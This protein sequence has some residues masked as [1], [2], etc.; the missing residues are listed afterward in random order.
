LIKYLHLFVSSTLLYL[1]IFFLSFVRDCASHERSSPYTL[2]Q[3]LLSGRLWNLSKKAEK[4]DKN[5]SE[6]WGQSILF[7]I[8]YFH[9]RG[10]GS[11]FVGSGYNSANTWEYSFAEFLGRWVCGNNWTEPEKVSTET[12]REYATGRWECLP[13]VRNSFFNFS[14]S[15][16]RVFLFQDGISLYQVL[17]IH[18]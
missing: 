16:V 10:Y 11:K 9:G 3:F 1:F 2:L 17:I 7:F 18:V 5:L 6:A 13:W 12:C 14:I 8:V 4:W 15:H